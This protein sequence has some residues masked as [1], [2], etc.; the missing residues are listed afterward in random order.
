M[1]WIPGNAAVPALSVQRRI[2]LA[3]DVFATLGMMADRARRADS[4]SLA[5]RLA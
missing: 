3:D 1:Q 5:V 4:T 2:A